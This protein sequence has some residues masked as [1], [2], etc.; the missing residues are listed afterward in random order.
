MELK[1]AKQEYLKLAEVEITKQ[2][3]ELKKQLWDYVGC[4]GL[5]TKEH[6]YMLKNT[7]YVKNFNIKKDFA[8][9]IL[10]C[11]MQDVVNKQLKNLSEKIDKIFL[12]VKGEIIETDLNINMEGEIV[13]TKGTW[14]IKT[15][16][17]EGEIQKLHTRFLVKKC[18]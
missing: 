16:Y 12:K 5:T 18:K 2:F 17:A 7:L 10:G 1:D 9:D 11:K 4:Y 15:I 13:T 14:N 6:C 8:S 3:T